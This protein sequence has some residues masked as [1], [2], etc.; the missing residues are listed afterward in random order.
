MEIPIPI[1]LLFT[2]SILDP[3]DLKPLSEFIK[4]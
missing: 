1:Y 4:M 2:L 3:K